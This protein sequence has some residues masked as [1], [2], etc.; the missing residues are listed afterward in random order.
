LARKAD[1]AYRAFENYEIVEAKHRGLEEIK[2]FKFTDYGVP[3]YGYL[4]I[5]TNQHN[6]TERR[7][8]ISRFFRAL[9]KSVEFIL[10]H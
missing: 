4:V 7:E 3:C 10:F 5:G 2:L 1:A 8:I 9:K 6:L